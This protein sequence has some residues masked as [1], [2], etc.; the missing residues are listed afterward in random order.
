VGDL[1]RRPRAVRQVVYGDVPYTA[2]AEARLVNPDGTLY[3][4]ATITCL[5]FE[6]AMR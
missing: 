2:T 3:A 5:I 4:Y 1:R 6:R